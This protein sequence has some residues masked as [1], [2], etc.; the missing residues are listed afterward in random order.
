[1]N[2]EHVMPEG[3]DGTQ[4]VSSKDCPCHPVLE[5]KDPDTGDEVWTHNNY[6]EGFLNASTK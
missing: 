2:D 3:C 5:S 4:H 6:Q 1:M